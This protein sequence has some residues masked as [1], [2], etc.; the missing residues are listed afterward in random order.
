MFVADLNVIINHT[1]RDI[2]DSFSFSFILF[3][4]QSFEGLTFR[5]LCPASL[6]AA[7]IMPIRECFLRC[8]VNYIDLLQF[9]SPYSKRLLDKVQPNSLE[10]AP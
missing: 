5:G 7:L 3:L 4:L 6:S 9:P 8:L 10:W 2:D 1:S